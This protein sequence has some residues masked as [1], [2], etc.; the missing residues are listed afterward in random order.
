VQEA[1]QI[2]WDPISVNYQLP[3]A[4]KIF[5]LYLLVVVTISLVKSVALLH[6]F[7]SFTHSSVGESRTENESRR[8]WETSSNKIQ[9]IKRFVFI[10]LLLNVLVAV[11]LLRAA[12][13]RAVEQK[14]FGPAALGGSIVEALTV[15]GLGI[16]VGAVLYAACALFEGKLLRKTRRNRLLSDPPP[17]A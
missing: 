2:G 17:E 11:L 8:A 5:I 12:L 3:W 7:W 1:P 16:L 14:M 4:A 13:V 10:T 6:Q 9:S 15:F